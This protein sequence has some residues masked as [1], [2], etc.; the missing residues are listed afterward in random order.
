MNERTCVRVCVKRGTAYSCVT[1][2]CVGH[3]SARDATTVSVMA[4]LIN[5]LKLNTGQEIADPLL[6]GFHWEKLCKNPENLA[7]LFGFCVVVTKALCCYCNSASNSTH[8][9]DGETTSSYQV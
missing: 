6:R 9:L 4:V 8:C 3:V 1:S 2:V 5:K 7:F